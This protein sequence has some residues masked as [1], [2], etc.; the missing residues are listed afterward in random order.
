MN[1]ENNKKALNSF[2][3][4]KD[5][6]TLHDLGAAFCNFNL[7]CFV[8]CAECAAFINGFC[9]GDPS[10]A[11]LEEIGEKILKEWNGNKYND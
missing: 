9:G 11:D 1:E 2:Y 6:F 10:A 5:K 3:G 7:H 4:K 8:P